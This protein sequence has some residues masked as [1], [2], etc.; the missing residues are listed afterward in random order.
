VKATTTDPTRSLIPLSNSARGGGVFD[1]NVN[2]Q[3]Y[4]S[5]LFSLS[6][7]FCYCRASGQQ[8]TIVIVS[9]T[10]TG[11]IEITENRDEK[12]SL[13]KNP[14]LEVL[15]ID[16]VVLDPRG[17]RT[18]ILVEGKLVLVPV[19]VRTVER[20]EVAIPN[21]NQDLLNQEAENELTMKRKVCFGSTC[22]FSVWSS[23]PLSFFFFLFFRINS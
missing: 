15:V 1:S 23:F 9:H 7:C 17:R 2:L 10:E 20:V 12:S 14:L 11:T 13:S 5:F 18:A 21:P 22:V 4:F 16:V 6:S 19:L 3:L 8:H